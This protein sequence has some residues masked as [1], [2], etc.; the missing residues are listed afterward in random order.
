MTNFQVKVICP[1]QHL[2][3]ISHHREAREVESQHENPHEKHQV[4]V[5]TITLLFIT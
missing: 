2:N 4:K 1:D 5:R 3:E